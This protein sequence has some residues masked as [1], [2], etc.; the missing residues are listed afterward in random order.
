[1]SGDI[2]LSLFSKMIK[3][4]KLIVCLLWTIVL[5]HI[6]SHV[7]IDA[8]EW[9]RCVDTAFMINP[10]NA[11]D[12]TD[13]PVAELLDIQP[14]YQA[15]I[16][17]I[18]RV[19]TDEYFFV[20]KRVLQQMASWENSLSLHSERIYPSTISCYCSHPACEYYVFALRHIIV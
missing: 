12:N 13:V 11:A 9:G 1:M 6:V 3:T 7:S 8:M 16:S 10:V 18:L 17:R 15:S 2:L 14:T 20:L 5:M 19:Q 4:V